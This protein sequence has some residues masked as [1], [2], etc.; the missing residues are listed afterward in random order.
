MKRQRGI[1]LMLVLWMLT[2]LTVMAVSMTAAQRTEMALTENHVAATRF[3]LLS[4]AAIAYTALRFLT[5][6][7]VEDEQLAPELDDETAESAQWQPNG[8]PHRWRFAG[9]ELTVSVFNELSRLNLNQTEPAVLTS[10]LEILGVSEDAAAQLADAIADWRDE[11]DLTQLNGAEDDDYRDAGAAIGAKDGPFVA[12]EEL[13]QVLG[14]TQEIYRRLAPEVTV[15]GE[16]ADPEIAF[17]S[18]AIL[19]ATQGIS[20]EEAQL[21][22]VERDT[23]TVPGARGPRAANRGGPLYRLQ[24]T[25]DM[26]GQGGRRMEALMELM[27]GQQPPYLVHWRRFNPLREAE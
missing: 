8:T 23:T 3:R 21:Q 6:D 5:P 1:A 18:P 12:V 10:L 9:T 26:A 25:D 11:D 27:P 17:A 22:I 4:D 19:A 13:R 24:V 14:I 15:E 20:L 2:L 7:G 16:G